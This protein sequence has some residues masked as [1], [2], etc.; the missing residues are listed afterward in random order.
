MMKIK[1]GKLVKRIDTEQGYIEVRE[2]QKYRWMCFDKSVFQTLINKAIPYEPTLGHMPLLL[3]GIEMIK[4]P[5]KALIMGLGGGALIHC[6]SHQYPD[7]KLT[8]VEISE[9][10]ISLAKEFFFLQSLEAKLDIINDDI[11]HYLNK[12]KNRF[13]IAFVDMY[14]SGKMPKFYFKS[15]FHQKI[16]NQLYKK[17]VAVYNLLCDDEQA[18]LTI[19]K[20]IRK[21]FSN[22]TLCI[23]VENYHNILLYAFNHENY[24]DTVYQLESQRVLCNL[25]YDLEIGLIA[26]LDQQPAHT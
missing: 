19:V 22:R 1:A 9:A 5:K 14:I 4:S 11:N 12:N 16:S 13:D 15:D 25:Q 10:V 6:I 18:F 24:K 7:L 21:I 26:E 17:G 8:A 20:C 2:N 3:K 23:A